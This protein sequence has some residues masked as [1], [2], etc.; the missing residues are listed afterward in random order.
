MSFGRLSEVKNVDRKSHL[1]DKTY[2]QVLVNSDQGL[3][4]L[5]LTDK[6]LQR[7][8]DRVTK[9]PEDTQMVPGWWDRVS[10]AF[11]GLL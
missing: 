7:V 4:T 2:F 9:N 6:E 10:A 1:A 11:S 3:E 5:L 8:R